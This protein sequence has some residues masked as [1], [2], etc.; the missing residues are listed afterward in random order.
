MKKIL[1]L[2]LVCL[3]LSACAPDP[4]QQITPRNVYFAG[5]NGGV[6]TAL[7]L[8]GN[9]FVEDPADADVIVLNGRIPSSEAIADAVR[10]G[11]GL[12]HGSGS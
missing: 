3:L 2:F 6:K 1:A 11:T 9:K 12:I 5:E 10:R 8:A 7:D 4:T